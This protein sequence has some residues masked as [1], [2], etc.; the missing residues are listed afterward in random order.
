MSSSIDDIKTLRK[1]TGISLT[2]CKKALDEASGDMEK[3]KEILREQSGV[4]LSKKADR[5]LG[6]GVVQAYIHST[7]DIGCMV[8]LL[9]ETDFVAKNEEFVSLA[10]DIAFH[11]AATQPTYMSQES[12]PKEMMDEYTAQVEKECSGGEGEEIKQ[13]KTRLK[14][15]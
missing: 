1:K 10:Y 11:I 15:I 6:A 9:C 7:K 2:A 4:A 14:T 12:V 8:E 5:N 3:A 13:K